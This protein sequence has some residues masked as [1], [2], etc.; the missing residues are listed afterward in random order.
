MTNIIWKKKILALIWCIDQYTETSGYRAMKKKP[1]SPMRSL[2]QSTHS[3]FIFK[4]ICFF[5]VWLQIFR[6]NFRDLWLLHTPNWLGRHIQLQMAEMPRQTDRKLGKKW[7]SSPSVI[8]EAFRDM[9]FSMFHRD[10]LQILIHRIQANRYL[11]IN[12]ENDKKEQQ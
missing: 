9:D 12:H 11:F 2:Q 10:T 7:K 4:I 6:A 3:N 5:P 1:Q 8:L